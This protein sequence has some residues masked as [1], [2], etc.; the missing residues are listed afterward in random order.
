MSSIVVGFSGLAGSGKSTSARLL[1]RDLGFFPRPFAGPLKGMLSSL[2]VPHAS[3]YG[4]REDKEHPLEC[5]GG[6]SARHA[7][8]TLG[9]DWGRNC[10]GK[11]FWVRQ[12]IREAVSLDRV[13]AD[14][15]RYP[16]EVDAIRS[17]GG[18]VYRI[19]RDDSGD[20]VNPRHSSEAVDAIDV[21]GVI[22]NNG[23]EAHLFEALRRLLQTEPA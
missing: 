17:L 21:D 12:W 14:D 4:A 2:G 13:V 9:T 11:D 3:L 15:V 5:L 10:M 8:Q 23:T 18:R 6:L 7:M 16:N 19:Q 20:R 1:V 22:D